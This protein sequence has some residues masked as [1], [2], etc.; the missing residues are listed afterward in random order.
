[1]KKKVYVL[2]VLIALLCLMCAGLSACGGGAQ[3]DETIEITG[4]EIT[5]G[6]LTVSM[7]DGWQLDA[8]ENDWA[9]G[10]RIKLLETA[11]LA[12]SGT[13]GYVYVDIELSD[14]KQ[15]ESTYNEESAKDFAKEY[16]DEN[17]IPAEKKFND[18]TY[19]GW[20]EYT[21]VGDSDYDW[22][23]AAYTSDGRLIEIRAFTDGDNETEENQAA[24]KSILASLRIG[25]EP[26]S[27]Q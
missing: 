16:D 25:G 11:N 17:A 7:P 5:S 21:Y 24:I 20:R 22:S 27:L 2:S 4:E 23:Y 14:Y 18:N 13:Y 6:D 26:L 1:M 12:S 3:E 9:A 15:I 10:E 8:K 19:L